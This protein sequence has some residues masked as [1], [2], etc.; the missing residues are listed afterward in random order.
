MG[1]AHVGCGKTFMAKVVAR[2][3]TRKN[4]VSI[5]SPELLT[6]WFGESEAKVREVRDK[7]RSRHLVSC[8]SMSSSQSEPLVEEEKAATWEVPVTGREVGLRSGRDQFG[9]ERL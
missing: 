3:R 7:E 8:S 9:A 4:F 2:E 1:H 6:L 5:K